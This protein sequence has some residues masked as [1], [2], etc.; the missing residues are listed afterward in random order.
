[1]SDG[2]GHEKY[3]KEHALWHT[4][5]AY[6]YFSAVEGLKEMLTIERHQLASHEEE[7]RAQRIAA[8]EF[9]VKLLE[10][11]TDN[12]LSETHK[13]LTVYLQQRCPHKRQITPEGQY[14]TF[15]CLDCG[16]IGDV[17]RELAG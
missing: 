7:N 12:E 14:T 4:W 15:Q 17:E 3:S 8:L 5:R 6:K 9:V 1:M 10:K 16:A 11:L 2:P 13:E